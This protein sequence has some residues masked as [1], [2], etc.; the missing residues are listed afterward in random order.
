M[1]SKETIAKLRRSDA[2]ARRAMTAKKGAPHSTAKGDMTLHHDGKGLYLQ[3]TSAGASWSQRFTFAGKRR[4]IGLGHIDQVSAAIAR[5]KGQAVR[6]QVA[7]GIDPVAARD[8]ETRKQKAQT[9]TVAL[10]VDRYIA[11]HAAEWRR[12]ETEGRHR[13]VFDDY[14][15][16]HIGKIA[17]A[18]LTVA[19]VLKAYQPDPSNPKVGFWR[20][21][22]ATAAKSRGWLWAALEA[23]R[24]KEGGLREDQRNPAEW[25]RLKADLPRPSKIAPTTNRAALPYKMIR[26]LI[27][28]IQASGDWRAAQA[29]AVILCGVRTRPVILMQ[30]GDIDLDAS[31]WMV[32]GAFE[33][34]NEKLRV[35]L[36][37]RLLEIIRAQ[38]PADGC[39]PEDDDYVFHGQGS[40][41]QGGKAQNLRKHHRSFGSLLAF[42]R[43]LGVPLDLATI[44]GFRSTVRDWAGEETTHPSDVCEAM[45]SHVFAKGT[46]GDYQRGSLF[47]KRRALMND[48]SDVCMGLR[49][50]TRTMDRAV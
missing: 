26:P 15:L 28:R 27:E 8:E 5:E 39:I 12:T 13:Q 41:R 4:W 9:L 25:D 35:P 37:P 6:D 3:V 22:T 2:A 46:R 18:D 42:L 20:D 50:A 34:S 30:W 23:T 16:P 7:R 40:G 31:E 11:V 1:L 47:D 14:L 38:L 17:V 21:H 43:K 29:E 45:L 19:Q 32:P 49:P 36:S 48:W 33:K 24:G 10:A 44:H